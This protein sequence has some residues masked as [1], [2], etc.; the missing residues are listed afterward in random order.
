MNIVVDELLTHYEMQGSGRTLLLLHG[1]GDSLVGLAGLSN[2][3]SAKYQVVSLDL[4]GF[5]TTQPPSA[6]WNLGNYASFVKD[7]LVKLQLKP[8]A[9]IG[10]SNGGALAIH[11]VASGEISTK[12]LVLLAASGIR[13]GHSTRRFVLKAVAKT[14]NVATFWLPKKTRQNLRKKLYG[15]AGSDLLV[16]EHLQET[17]KQTVRQDVQADAAK[18]QLPTL[19]LFADQDKAVPISDGHTYNKLIKNSHLEIISGASHFLH[20]DEPLKVTQ[21]IEYFLK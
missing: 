5:G 10:H 7:F 21:E 14:G 16:V 18:L 6:V 11:A 9:V 8:Y 17:F 1:W 19:L 3:L 15:A 2:S 4:P 12:K 13:T 20:L